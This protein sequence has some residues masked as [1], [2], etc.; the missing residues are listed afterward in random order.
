MGNFDDIPWDDDEERAAAQRWE[1]RTID[2]TC[3]CREQRANL[4]TAYGITLLYYDRLL[5]ALYA[6]R[7]ITDL[8][9]Y[10]LY[11][12]KAQALLNGLRLDCEGLNGEYLSLIKR[13]TDYDRYD[14]EAWRT[15]GYW[16]TILHFALAYGLVERALGS[17]MQAANI[18]GHDYLISA[19]AEFFRIIYGINR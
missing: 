17:A 1:Q 8:G 5:A 2:L 11:L 19:E 10:K 12:L 3:K 16:T 4:Q 15:R 7:Q 18:P 14:T 9:D 6:R 13:A